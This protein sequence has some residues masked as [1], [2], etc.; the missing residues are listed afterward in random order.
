MQ[1]SLGFQ[2]A[3]G[4]MRNVIYCFITRKRIV[5]FVCMFFVL[6]SLLPLADAAQEREKE[7][8]RESRE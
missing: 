3:A 1:R 2:W 4:R 7:R 6:F 5:L 8:E